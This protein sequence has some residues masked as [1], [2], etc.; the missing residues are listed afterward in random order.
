[1]AHFSP[2]AAAGP[3]EA[4]VDDAQNNTAAVYFDFDNLISNDTPG[5]SGQWLERLV[6][7]LRCKYRVLN[8]AAYGDWQKLAA[9]HK[10][11]DTWGIECI[12]VSSNTRGGKNSADVE[13]VVDVME[14]VSKVLNIC[15]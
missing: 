9:W 2:I 1:M 14:Y 12:D 5:S 4:A 8:I 15:C 10:T 3:Y 11:L 7:F 6:Q 13:A